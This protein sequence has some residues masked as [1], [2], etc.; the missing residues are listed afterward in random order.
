M[1]PARDAGALFADPVFWGW[2]VPR[3]DGHA[4]IALPGLG[5]S[6]T[7]LG[8]LRS[9][10]R[11]VGYRTTRSGIE[12]NRG[13]SRE[14]VEEIASL[15]EQEAKATGRPVT[16]VGHSMGGVIAVSAARR[17]PAAIRQVIALGSPLIGVRG[18]LPASVTLTSLY[19]KA[20]PIVRYPAAVPRLA[21]A[22][23]IEVS[24]SHTGLATNREVYRHLGRLLSAP[25]PAPQYL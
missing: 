14:V 5:G 23:S 13:W 9:W 15:A 20:D 18:E 8:T 6:D 12:R 25:Q 24:G 10:L 22:E 11:R 17:A 1:A 19:S 7:Y 3:G 4:V 16:L 21:R 2:G